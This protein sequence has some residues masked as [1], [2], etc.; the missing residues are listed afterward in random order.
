MII[1]TVN[2]GS[3]SVRLG[4]FTKRENGIERLAAGKYGL[5]GSPSSVLEQF[6][7]DNGIPGISVNSHR[8]VHGGTQ[9]VSSCVINA[10]VET[11]IDRL[12]SLA[13]L[14]NP[15]ALKWIRACRA[16]FGEHVPQV[17]VFDTAFYSSMPEVAA[18]YA[19]PKD[20]CSTHGIRR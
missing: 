1:L 4:A 6:V 19:L 13:P 10:D 12:S 17:A 20:L 15:H 3:S 7:I 5:E 8:V 18:T 11:E 2:T 14:H 16:S 9:F